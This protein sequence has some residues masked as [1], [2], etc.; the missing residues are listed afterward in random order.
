M[1]IKTSLGIL[2][3]LALVAI[4]AAVGM[5]NQP[6]LAHPVRLSSTAS[7]PLWAAMLGAFLSGLLVFVLLFIL[8]GSTD[9]LDRVKMLQ[10]RR[11]GRAVDEIYS[12][13][14]EAVL[15]GREEKAL[16]HFQAILS[17]DP[18]H[19]QALVKAGAVLRTLKKLPEAVEMHKRAHRLRESALE[20]LYELV[21]DYESLDQIAKARV[22]LNR[23]IQLRPRRA[24]SA[25][26]KLRKY[27]M[28][29]GD[30]ARAW[31]LQGLIENQMEKTPH[32]LEAE[33]RYSVGI[34]YEMAGAAARDGREKDALN[35]LRRITRA[36][37]SFIP[38]HVRLGE[39]LRGM[40]QGAQAVRVWAAGWDHTNAPVFLTAI[41]EYF[42]S[43]ESPEEAIEALRQ[44]AD[45]SRR[46]F[47]PRFALARLYMRLEMID[48]AFREFNAL[49]SRATGSITMH[50]Y[51]GLVRERRG[52]HAAAVSEYRSV[53]D[54]LELL[55]QQYRCQLC[56]ERYEAWADRC[57]VC[58]EWNQVALDFGEDPTL[59]DLGISTGPVYSRTA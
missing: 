54:Q 9:L 30:W 43:E 41:E 5:Q 12:R 13:G 48:E 23:I 35:A 57:R 32:K 26:R 14:M 51:V 1:Q 31:E 36:E 34:R 17:R 2:A 16:E 37:P 40:R 42:L 52:E 22:V 15:E 25:Y 55:K 19:L 50:A 21:K 24:L 18:E 7:I 27:A 38:A 33:R 45:R 44:A 56:E 11:A 10:G 6:L 59:E 58:G 8:R 49:A 29:E 4:L 3:A 47:L 28:N 46:D 53:L 20:P 39:I